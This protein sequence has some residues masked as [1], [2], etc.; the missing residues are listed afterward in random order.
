MNVLR[1]DY[2]TILRDNLPV[3]DVRAP[4]EYEKGALPNS[5]N[6]PILTDEERHRVGLTYKASGS[7]S[8]TQLGQRLVSG[9]EKQTRVER[10][11]SFVDA[12]PNA[13]LTCWRGG[14]RSQIA[15][16]WLSDAGYS[17][18]RLAAGFKGMRNTS[19]EILND[20]S[21]RSWVVI[22]GQTGVGKTKLLT[23]FT[24]SIDL[25]GL[26]RHR[27]SSFGRLPD[28]QPMP[29]SFELALAQRL[30]Q[31]ED[32]QQCLIEDESRTIGRL[33]VPSVLFKSMQAAP[34]VILEA[35]LDDRIALTID[36][37]VRG[38]DS[39]NLRNA[40]Q[41]IAKRLG[42]ERYQQVSEA[43]EKAIVSQSDDDHRYWVRSLF[44]FYYDP[45]YD[46]QLQKK[47]DRVIF[48]G[49]HDDVLGFLRERIGTNQVITV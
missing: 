16:E 13:L 42:L 37:Y 46:Y 17:V 26:A 4:S 5:V 45:M 18:A 11:S 34:V 25:E 47:I 40:L 15:Q 41:R 3:L 39:E 8:A 10:W 35:P 48:Q 1:D 28:P 6:E 9:V 44:D 12:N 36:N 24:N 20:C 14:Q 22:A 23:Q 29:V 43:L 49:N 21:T 2:R 31:T 19:I 7:E 30:L 38:N 33:G 27:G 32:T